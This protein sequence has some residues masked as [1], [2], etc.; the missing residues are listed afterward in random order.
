MTEKHEDRLIPLSEVASLL[1][2]SKTTVWEM[3]RRGLLPKPLKFGPRMSRWRLSD[4]Q[5]VI[6]KAEEAGRAA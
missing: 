3:V 2:M 5:K 6:A 4:I 1:G